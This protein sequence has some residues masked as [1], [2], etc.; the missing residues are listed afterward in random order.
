M[1][2][3]RNTCGRDFVVGD[4]HGMFAVL[5]RLL[6]AIHFEPAQDRLFSVGDLVDRGPDSPRALAYLDKPWFHAIRGNHEDILVKHC[7]APDDHALYEQWMRNGGSWW[8]DTT[9]TVRR[10]LYHQLS[11]LP[12]AMEVDTQRGLVGI[13]HA[14]L[15]AEH[16]WPAFVAALK[17]GDGQ[18]ILTALWSRQRAKLWRIA[19]RVPGVKDIYCGHTMVKTPRS[20]GNVHYI[21]TGACHP[22]FGQLTAVNLNLGVTSAVTVNA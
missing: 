11:R 3:Q 6:E 17:G 4:L 12:L 8:K 19:A 13:V 10:Q 20:A 5:E 22:A 1:T 14:D 16:D 7:E 18:A 2:L 9:A 15:P 21:D